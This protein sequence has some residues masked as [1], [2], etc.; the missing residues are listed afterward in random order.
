MIEVDKELLG[1]AWSVRSES[2]PDK[3][4]L[5]RAIK[6]A[7]KIIL[8]CPCPIWI[9]N[10]NNR[11]CKHTEYAKDILIKPIAMTQ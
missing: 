7:G 11:E 2:K 6:Y 5:V 3:T 10:K 9:F 1:T 8:S 4:Y